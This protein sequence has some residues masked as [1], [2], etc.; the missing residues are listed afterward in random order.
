MNKRAHDRQR[1]H[2]AKRRYDLVNHVGGGKVLD[3]AACYP[4]AFHLIVID[5]V[6]DVADRLLT[7]QAGLVEQH[8]QL[9]NVVAPED[10]VNSYFKL[11][12]I[13][14]TCMKKQTR[15]SRN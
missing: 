12:T 15:D 9:C 7:H 6:M 3:I 1:H 14:R 2:V 5:L 13:H 10:D 11:E 8:K 4:A